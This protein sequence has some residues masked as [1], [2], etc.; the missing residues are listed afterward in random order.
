MK[1][2]SWFG[3]IVRVMVCLPFVFCTTAL[4][5]SNLKP[6]AV[7]YLSAE[8]TYAFFLVNG[9]FIVLRGRYADWMVELQRREDLTATLNQALRNQQNGFDFWDISELRERVQQST[10]PPELTAALA[11]KSTL[12]FLGRA[13]STTHGG[14]LERATYWPPRTGTPLKIDA[15]RLRR[16]VELSTV[17]VFFAAVLYCIGIRRQELRKRRNACLSCGYCLMGNTTGVCSE[18]GTAVPG[19]GLASGPAPGIRVK[20]SVRR[21]RFGVLV[22]AMLCFPFVLFTAILVLARVYPEA[23]T[24]LTA[25]R[26]YAHFL[27]EDQLVAVRG[28]FEDWMIREQRQ[29]DTSQAYGTARRNQQDAIM[30]EDLAFLRDRVERSV[31]R[32]E[33]TGPMARRLSVRLLTFSRKESHA[34]LWTRGTFR[35][36]RADGL[37]KVDAVDLVPLVGWSA[38]PP[39]VL[40]VMGCL[41]LLQRRRLRRLG[42]CPFCG[43]DLADDDSGLCTACGTRAEPAD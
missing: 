39:A 15:F 12:F 22:R 18:C 10:P 25:D 30:R 17:P 42:D 4:L 23:A 28:P 20:R 5:V 41:D 6:R 33:L 43:C 31:P 3:I 32:Q 38:I 2:G 14:V 1:R 26:T 16:I 21:G 35:P 37:V 36:A 34:G 7:G 40:A 24:H 9:R 27:V 11:R 19:R 13:K 8:H 29:R